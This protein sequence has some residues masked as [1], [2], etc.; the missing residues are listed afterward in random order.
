MEGSRGGR[1]KQVVLLYYESLVFRVS[2]VGASIQRWP[3]TYSR[4]AIATAWPSSAAPW[5]PV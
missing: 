4:R 2:E 5:L 1:R 3:H